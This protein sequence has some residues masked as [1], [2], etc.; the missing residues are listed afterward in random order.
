MNSLL[1]TLKEIERLLSIARLQRSHLAALIYTVTSHNAEACDLLL[2]QVQKI[3]EQ[4]NK[5]DRLLES[6]Y[7][8]LGKGRFST[9]AEQTEDN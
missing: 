5:V 1:N 8:T 7:D 9:G 3:S 2:A 6:L 4:E